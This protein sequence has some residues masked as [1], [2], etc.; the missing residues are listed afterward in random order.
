ML[1]DGIL[2][3]FFSFMVCLF[4]M[5]FRAVSERISSLFSCRYICLDPNR[6]SEPELVMFDCRPNR[7]S[8]C[9]RRSGIRQIK[10]TDKMP[11]RW[12]KPDGKCH[13]DMSCRAKRFE[14]RFGLS[15]QTCPFG[16]QFLPFC[17]IKRA[18]LHNKRARCGLLSDGKL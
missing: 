17:L 13:N 12:T 18:L 14:N 16:L 9:C 15:G 10:T 6:S 3:S 11:A 7:L 4:R 5:S 2:S 1:N 8:V